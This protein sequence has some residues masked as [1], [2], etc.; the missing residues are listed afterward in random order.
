HHDTGRI[1]QKSCISLSKDI[2]VNSNF[3]GILTLILRKG[4]CRAVAVC[5]SVVAID[6]TLW[7]LGKASE[8][9]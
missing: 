9:I 8:T 7:R 4:W 5:D 6:Q 1:D 3:K 2:S